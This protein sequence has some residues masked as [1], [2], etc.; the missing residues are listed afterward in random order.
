MLFAAAFMHLSAWKFYRLG[1]RGLPV[2]HW[3]HT[4]KYSTTTTCTSTTC[5]CNMHVSGMLQAGQFF[6]YLKR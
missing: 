2:V 6:F 5:L 4:F 1:Q 3:N